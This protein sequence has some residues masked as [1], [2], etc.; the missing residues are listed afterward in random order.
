MLADNELDRVTLPAAIDAAEGPLTPAAA[1]VE[2]PTA[3]AED[4]LVM[5]AL[6]TGGN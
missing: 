1:T 5:E 4:A 2:N 3:P 6:L